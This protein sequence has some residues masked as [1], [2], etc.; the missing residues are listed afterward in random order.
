MSHNRVNRGARKIPLEKHVLILTSGP[1][2]AV[3]GECARGSAQTSCKWDGK[4][5]KEIAQ[6]YEG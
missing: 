2:R 5:G 1:E 4:S 3:T 6:A